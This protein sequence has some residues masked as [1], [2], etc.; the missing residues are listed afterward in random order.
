M[1]ARDYIYVTVLCAVITATLPTILERL[2]PPDMPEQLRADTQRILE[3]QSGKSVNTDGGNIITGGEWVTFK[4]NVVYKARSNG[5]VAAYS[6]GK[7][8][9]SKGIILEGGTEDTLESRTRFQ[10]YDGA[11][12]PVQ[13]GRFWLVQGSGGT[14]K[15]ITVQ[16]MKLP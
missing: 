5:I 16:W 2:I 1:I 4:P 12:L 15:S 8:K 13:K 9:V 11:V 14:S 6:G 10:K 3:N 7:G